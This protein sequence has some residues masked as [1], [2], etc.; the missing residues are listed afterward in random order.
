MYYYISEE[1]G[2]YQDTNKFMN[3][4]LNKKMKNRQQL[5]VSLREETNEEHSKKPIHNKPLSQIKKKAGV[6]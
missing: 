3:K 5:F 4:Q 1:Q 6:L 2:S